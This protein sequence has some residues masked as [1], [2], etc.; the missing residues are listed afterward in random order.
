MLLREEVQGL[1]ALAVGVV[2]LFHAGFD[3]AIGGYVGVDVF[4]VISGFL[5]TYGLIRE[6]KENNLGA[7]YIRRIRRLFPA[8][9][10]TS[11][12]TFIASWLIMSEADF[13]QAARATIYA[14]ISISNIGFWLETGYWDSAAHYKPLLHTWSLSVEEQFYLIWPA[15]MIALLMLG[16]KAILVL[17][18]A[19][20]IGGAIAA[21]YFVQTM[22]SAVFYLT[23][24]RA[25]QFAIGA[26]YA[27]LL[28]VM[29]RESIVS[30]AWVQ[31]LMI[32][33]GLALIIVPTF[34]YVGE[35][36]TY[37]GAMAAIPCVGALLV[38]M[39]G[40]G[41]LIG[42]LLTNPVSTYVGNISYSLYLTHWPLMALYRYHVARDFTLP[43]Q[44]ILIAL[45]VITALG[46]YYG[47]EARFRRPVQRGL[48][49]PLSS[50]GFGFAAT[51]VA[52]LV[53]IAAAHAWANGGFGP[54]PLRASQSDVLALT[55]RSY[56]QENEVR[57]QHLPPECFR[58]RVKCLVLS[59]RKQNILIL[60]DSHGIDIMNALTVTAPKANVMLAATNGCDT[61]IGAESI[62]KRPEDVT[63]CVK[64]NREIFARQD[65]F[66]NSD[67]IIM[68]FYVQSDKLP[69]IEDTI[70]YVKQN[71]NAEIVLFSNSPIYVDLLTS[72]AR[73]QNI[74]SLDARIADEFIHPNYVG[75]RDAL[76]EIADRT[77]V[78]YIDKHALFCPE[79][80]CRFITESGTS[81][82]S[83]DKHHL[84]FEAA[85][86]LGNWLKDQPEFMALIK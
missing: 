37:L 32:V 50:G 3:W 49:A 61:L 15:L 4:F 74:S 7:F 84:S 70:E 45:T 77:G 40:P 51:G 46:L 29:K 58:N 39:A 71:S 20:A 72:I 17:L 36:P 38:I 78:T 18:L 31:D 22:P 44:L 21:Q 63:R 65:V 10:V 42:Y 43:E 14:I 2:I 54:S 53:C 13:A 6:G 67:L 76:V 66:E 56:Q 52:F 8:L 75:T 27:A 24:F 83:Y 82:I 25:Y 34:V 41:K 69:L 68:N 47:V 28:V 73:S 19:L 23:P 1:R 11:V 86:E 64:N 85:Q 79:N 16:R 26:A 59:P 80:K 62:Y 35:D 30:N 5:I 57:Y 55:E 12:L 60:G 48:R 9:L 81:L 33:A